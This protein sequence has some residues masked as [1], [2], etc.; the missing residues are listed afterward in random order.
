M[1]GKQMKNLFKVLLLSIVMIAIIGCGGKPGVKSYYHTQKGTLFQAGGFEPKAELTEEYVL[2]PADVI[3][4]KV[5]GYEDLQQVVTIP[6]NGVATFFPVGKIKVSGLTPSEVEEVFKEKLKTYVKEIPSVTVIVKEYNYYRLYVLGEVNK[7]GLYPYPG[8]IT[9]L[10]A[11]TMAGTYTRRAEITRVSV[12]RIDK[13]DPTIARVAT[14]NLRDIIRKGDVSQ[15]IVLRP[16]DIIYVPG[17]IMANINDI[18][19]QITPSVSTVYYVE[20]L[21]D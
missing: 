11:I 18:I 9:V 12:V 20:A 3:E 2:G 21:I 16:G 1:G 4:V 5:W 10:E 8:R 15:D 7:P 13:K 6:P 14:V 19:N 17:S